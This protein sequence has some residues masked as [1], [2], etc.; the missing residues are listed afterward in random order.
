MLRTDVAKQSFPLGLNLGRRVY[1]AVG[2]FCGDPDEL[3]RTWFALLLHE[4]LGR[5]LGRRAALG[6][7]SDPRDAL[8][9]TPKEAGA[10]R[11]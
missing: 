8:V 11:T 7:E 6:K 9:E 5:S 4:L 10:G 2:A 3:K 1:D